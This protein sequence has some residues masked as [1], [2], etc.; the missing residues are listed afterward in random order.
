[1]AQHAMGNSI[2]AWCSWLY[3]SAVCAQKLALAAW[4]PGSKI[5]NS[6]CRNLYISGL[7]I[8]SVFYINVNQTDLMY[9]LFPYCDLIFLFRML[10][11]NEV[12]EYCGLVRTD[13]L[14]GGLWVPGR[15]FL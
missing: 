11:P 3:L 10:S 14:L 8:C 9:Q 13:D 12:K 2:S 5:Q 4:N 15:F 1:M 6:P 7:G